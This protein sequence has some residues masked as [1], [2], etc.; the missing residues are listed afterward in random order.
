MMMISISYVYLLYS[1]LAEWQVFY[2]CQ[3]WWEFIWFPARK[4]HVEMTLLEQQDDGGVVDNENKHK[5]Q[6]NKSTTTTIAC[7]DP[8]TGQYLG[9][10][11]AM[12]P[13]QVE[14]ACAQAAAAQKDWAHT[15]FRQRRDVLRTLQHYL[16][17]HVHDICRVSARD[18]GKSTV[19]ACL[20]EVLT[21]AEKIRCLVQHGQVW[22]R[23]SFRP[24]GP[25]MLHKTAVVEY[26]P[27]GVIAAIAPWNYP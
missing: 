15:T 1:K 27:L 11:P 17:Q 16:L 2:T 14:Q 19:D 25:L 20:G 6:N 7:Y 18:S 26:V 10:V 23:P 13:A 12:T 21:T 5:N 8:S 3:L 9:A 4:I 22:L 24:T